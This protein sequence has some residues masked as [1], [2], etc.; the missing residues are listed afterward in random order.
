MKT[1]LLILVSLITL[2]F[3][4]G[5][6]QCTV[7]ATDFGN[8]TN[9]SSYNITGDVSVTLNPNN[10]ATLSLGSNFATAA[11]PDVRAYLV[12]SN[13]ASNAAINNAVHNQTIDNVDHIPFNGIVNSNGADSFTASIPSGTVIEDFDKVLFYCLEF[14]Q[15]WDIGDFTPFS[16]SNCAILSIDNTNLN[17][18]FKIHPNPASDFIIIENTNKQILSVSVYNVL[19]KKVLETKPSS[20]L[21]IK[22]NLTSLKAGV[23]LLQTTSNGVVNTNRIIKQYFK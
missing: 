2:C 1:K 3:S 21:K 13:G 17:P 10:T 14:N 19:G 12:K 20:L 4:K 16:A 8:N 11:G 18:S 23:Y 9:V 5:N 15:F 6:A 22:L 7:A